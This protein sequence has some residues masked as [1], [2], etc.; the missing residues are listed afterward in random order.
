MATNKNKQEDGPERIL[1]S[2][3]VPLIVNAALDLRKRTQKTKPLLKALPIQY[4]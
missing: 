2:N 3:L 1:P 4:E